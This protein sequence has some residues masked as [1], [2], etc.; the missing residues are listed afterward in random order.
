MR[1]YQLTNPGLESLTLVELP[2][3]EPGPGQVLVRMRA[4]SLNYRDLLVATNRYGRGLPPYPLIPLSDGAGEIISVGDGVQ[5]L[6]VG[7]RVIGNFFQ[8]WFDGPFDKA[9]GA[10]ALGGA[11]DGVLAEF[12]LFNEAAA[13]RIPESLSFEEASTLPCAGL[14]AWVALVTAGELKPS[15]TVLV[16]GT[17][18][19]SIFGLQIAKQL[20]AHVIITSSDDEK[21]ARARQLGADEFVNYKKSPDWDE[22]VLELTSGRGVDQVL[23]VGG[24][25]TLPLSLRATR[26]GGHIA[27]IGLLTGSFPNVDAAKQND[28]RARI[29]SIYVGSA[30]QLSNLCEF[31]GLG[32]WRPV[33]DRVFSFEA[34]AEAY[35]YLEAQKHFGK[36]VVRF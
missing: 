31:I 5:R 12:V 17:G 33:V 29:S 24:S 28:R 23:E 8:Q 2:M 3:P 19:V 35:G 7:D 34:V 21:L 13:V 30:H 36:I 6:K 22:S 15:D 20:G 4:S 27:L 18:G 9:K 32:H 26:V 14:T 10:S 11:I 25:E 1:A 16:M